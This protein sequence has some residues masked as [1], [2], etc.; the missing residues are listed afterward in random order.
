MVPFLYA[1]RSNFILLCSFEVQALFDPHNLKNLTCSMESLAK[2]HTQTNTLA[3]TAHYS[4]NTLNKN[5][6]RKR[7]ITWKWKAKGKKKKNSIKFTS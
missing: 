1:E 7:I 2:Y 5:L 4:N 6:T 3:L